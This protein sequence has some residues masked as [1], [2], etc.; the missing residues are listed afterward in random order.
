MVVFG[1]GKQHADCESDCPILFDIGY[2]Q[3]ELVGV[4]GGDR[5]LLISDV[6]LD[7]EG[8]GVCC[9]EG[10]IKTVLTHYW[11]GDRD[12]ERLIDDNGLESGFGELIRHAVGFEEE[13]S[14]DAAG[15]FSGE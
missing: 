7:G 4:T 11:L 2:G 10:V 13:E 8:V 6:Y 14:I 9:G 12:S 1:G 5:G 3:S 15:L